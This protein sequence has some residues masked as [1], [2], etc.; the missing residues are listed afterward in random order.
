MRQ[1][2]LKTVLE[3]H[4]LLLKDNSGVNLSGADLSRADL[5]RADLRYADLSSANLSEADLIRANLSRANLRYADL[6]GA[7]LSG[8][9]LSWAIGNGNEIKSLQLSNYFITYTATHMA[10]GCKQYSIEHWYMLGNEEISEMAGDA[11][12]WWEEW[13]PKLVALGVFD[14]VKAE[15][16]G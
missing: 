6:S 2:E 4:Q 5:S 7:N 13:K 9:N 15:Q 8:A 1:E 14:A 12:S 11:L 16:E 10:I 3:Q